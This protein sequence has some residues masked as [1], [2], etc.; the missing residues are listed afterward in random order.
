MWFLPMISSPMRTKIK[1]TKK[2]SL[3]PMLIEPH[4][5]ISQEDAK[6]F[7]EILE[8]A[9]IKIKS[10]YSYNKYPVH[11]VYFGLV[12]S[13]QVT[14]CAKYASLTSIGKK[15]PIFGCHE[16]LIVEALL[17]EKTLLSLA[18]RSKKFQ[19][20]LKSLAKRSVDVRAD[21][22][23][24]INNAHLE[25]KKEHE[26]LLNDAKK[27]TTQKTLHREIYKIADKEVDSNPRNRIFN[28]KVNEVL[29]RLKGRKK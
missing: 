15:N 26:K 9:K 29:E 17:L 21:F 16:L 23:N 19:T 12:P 18:K 6:Q 4:E 25:L 8:R 2:T 3:I 11:K 28:A 14:D 7:I 1:S 10:L 13:N 24:T 20:K 5:D 27:L 22:K